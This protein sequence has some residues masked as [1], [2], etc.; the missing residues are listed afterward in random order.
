MAEASIEP[1]TSCSIGNDI[2]NESWSQILNL[3][4]INNKLKE[5]VHNRSFFQ[6]SPMAFSLGVSLI[7]FS[8]VCDGSRI[9]WSDLGTGTADLLAPTPPLSMLLA[10]LSLEITST[11]YI[12][13]LMRLSLYSINCL[14]RYTGNSHSK[15]AK[16]F[17][18]TINPSS[19]YSPYLLTLSQ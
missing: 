7:Y 18:Q 19:G 11:N 16:I 5:V 17:I 4:E 2:T 10:R 9:T 1:G 12:N 6:S 8:F 15:T 14:Y 3:N 13:I